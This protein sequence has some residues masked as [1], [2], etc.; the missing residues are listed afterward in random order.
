MVRFPTDLDCSTGILH[1]ALTI[2]AEWVQGTRCEWKFICKKTGLFE[3]KLSFLKKL[4][5]LEWNK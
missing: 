5:L 4:G 2:N 3:K 1:G